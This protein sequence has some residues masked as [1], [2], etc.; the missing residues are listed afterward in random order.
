MRSWCGVY[1]NAKSWCGVYNNAKGQ[2]TLRPP[3]AVRVFASQRTSR[4]CGFAIPPPRCQKSSYINKIVNTLPSFLGTLLVTRSTVF[5]SPSSGCERRRSWKT[6]S[7]GQSEHSEP[8]C[9]AEPERKRGEGPRPGREGGQRAS[10][11]GGRGGRGRI[12]RT[13]KR[14]RKKTAKD[15]FHGIFRGGEGGGLERERRARTSWFRDKRAM[16]RSC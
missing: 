7:V 15:V 12:R 6:G 10:G 3:V 4:P 5:M 16:K 13:A 14:R 8:E 1:N 2:N 9:R 11:R